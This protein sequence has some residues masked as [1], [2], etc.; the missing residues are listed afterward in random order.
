MLLYKCINKI[1]YII[2]YLYYLHKEI[3]IKTKL[4]DFSSAIV[5]ENDIIC[6]ILSKPTFIN[7][8]D[9]SF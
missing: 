4:C 7:F 5:I 3:H 6:I 8:K 2:I 9:E 1:K